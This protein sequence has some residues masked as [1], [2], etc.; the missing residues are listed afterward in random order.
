MGSRETEGHTSQPVSLPPGEGW[1]LAASGQL[2]GTSPC[3][4]V[5]VV[6]VGRKE[7]GE[8]EGGARFTFNFVFDLGEQAVTT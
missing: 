2:Q 6:V 1:G 8:R 5:E 3:A 4:G 7:G